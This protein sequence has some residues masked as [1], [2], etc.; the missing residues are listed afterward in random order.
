MPGC[1]AQAQDGVRTL[2][3]FLQ[4]ARQNSPLLLDNAGQVAQVR[5]DSLRRRALQRPQVTG[6]AAA[7]AAPIIRR[8]TTTGD[9]GLGY[10]EAVSNG[11]NYTAYVGAT[12]PLFNAPTLRNDY[13]VLANQ[14]VALRNT[15][16]LAAL[17]LRR[18][19]T[20]QFLTAFAAQQQW[21]YSQSLLRQLRQQDELL[22]RLVNGGVYKQTQYLTYY[23]SVR[24]QEVT[25][26][27]NELSYRR[28]LGTLRYL[29]G[30]IDTTLLLVERPAPP[31]HRQL[32]GL[33]SITQQQYVLDSLRIG[34]ARRAIDLTYRPQVS[35][36]ADI[37]LQSSTL[38]QFGNH[39]GFSGGL[40]L[41]VPIFDGHQRQIA[42]SRLAVDDRIR[43][44][45]RTFLTRQRRQQYDQLSGLARASDRLLATIRQQISI[46]N[47]LI[48][49]GRSQLAAGDI[50]ILDYL[51]LITGYRDLQF[52]LA[53]AETE[54]LRNLYALDYLAE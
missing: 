51:L 6:N 46:A 7:V 2:D 3:A 8:N 30:V 19:I 50:S 15:G 4:L 10:D 9:G 31:T 53:Q 42:Y 35:W 11:G 49:A 5:L 13:Q 34:L 16:R 44:G 36:V 43:Q 22:R 32:A 41:S 40:V 25:V 33:G 38:Q 47:T 17:D 52:S 20:D 45:Y 48:E 28:E 39:A 21:S 14:G 18:S 26:L 1:P 29:S 23:A 27:Q 37:G 24:N 12:Q 54:R